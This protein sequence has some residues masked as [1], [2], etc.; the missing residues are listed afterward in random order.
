[1]GILDFFNQGANAIAGSTGNYGGLLSD[2]ERKAIDGQRRMALAASLLE[3]AGP[4]TQRTSLTQAL[5]RSMGAANQAGSAG[6]DQALQAALLRKQ[7]SAM[8]RKESLELK[9]IV[10]PVTGKPKLVPMSEAR[11][12]EPW[13]AV[14]RAEAPAEIQLYNL[15]SEQEKAAGRTP[16]NHKEWYADRAKS[17][18]GAPYA[19]MQVAGASGFGNRTNATFTPTSTATDEA[20]AAAQK[21]AE[22]E[23]AAALAKE[24]ASRDATFENDINVISD[25]IERTDRLLQDFLSGKYQTGPISGRLPNIRT[26][27]QDLSREQG[28]DTIKNISSATFGALS[29][30]ERGFLKELGVSENSN[31]ESNINLL[32]E[33][34]RVLTRAKERLLKRP[35]LIGGGGSQQKDGGSK[36]DPLGIR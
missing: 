15:Y 36:E 1:M 35:T 29:E 13:A 2:E 21:K 27:A 4:S 6:L 26:S 18:V 25:E 33:R 11:N 16:L 31:E 7:L 20:A 19:P 24:Q 8:D 3:S 23:R 12:Q 32:R 22:E 9:A 5:G 10:D 14:Q 17:G 30:G 28:K 34:K